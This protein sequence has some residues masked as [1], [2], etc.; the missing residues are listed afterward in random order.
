[1]QAKRCPGS[2]GFVQPKPE[3]F[4]CP[5]CGREVEIWSDEATRECPACGKTVFRPGMQSCLDWC[6]HAVECVGDEKL[7]QYVRMKGMMR[8]Q[9]L[10]RAMEDYFG[11]DARRIRHAQRTAEYAERI[12]ADTPEADPN[13]VMAAAYLHDI[14]IRNAEAKYGS[15]DAAHQ[16]TEGPP[17][18]RDILR[19]LDYAEAFIGEV[20]DIVGR[21]HH[22]RPEETANFKALYD[23][24]QLVNAEESLARANEPRAAIASRLLT[25]AGRKLSIELSLAQPGNRRTQ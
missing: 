22:P 19:R 11:D 23:A 24:D 13:I 10:A 16:E 3:M 12:L 5:A 15:A 1:M 18:A 7:A 14:G 20:C 8:K 2:L 4:A 6:K 21:H 9:A 17:V 25:E